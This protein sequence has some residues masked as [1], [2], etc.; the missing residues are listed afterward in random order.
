MVSPPPPA[1]W[2]VRIRT[3]VNGTLTDTEWSPTQASGLFIA[4]HPAQGRM[5][6]IGAS[7]DID[8]WSLTSLDSS[9]INY[10]KGNA[11]KR[12]ALIST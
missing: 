12:L 7:L 11:E 9:S 1:I 10:E 6:S 4:F 5:V 8:G 3:F 2:R